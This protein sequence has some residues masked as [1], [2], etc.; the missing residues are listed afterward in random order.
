VERGRVTFARLQ[1]PIPSSDPCVKAIEN[2]QIV[3]SDDHGPSNVLAE[4]NNKMTGNFHSL[5]LS[6]GISLPNPQFIFK[7]E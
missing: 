2:Q 4:S 1:L 5:A 6:I 3:D 7:H